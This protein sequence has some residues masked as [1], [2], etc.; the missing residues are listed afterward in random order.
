MFKII[1]ISAIVILAIGWIAYG[2]WR[3]K[4]YFDEKGKPEPTT[5][6]LQTKRKSFE[7]YTKKLA[8]YKRKP[9]ERQ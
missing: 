2:A 6:H 5:K 4:T 1:I 3:I 7:E 8:D 9:Y